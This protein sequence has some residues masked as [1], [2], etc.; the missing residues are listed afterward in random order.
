M[1][2]SDLFRV[3][4]RLMA[5]DRSRL[6]TRIIT[7]ILSA[8]S[9]MLFA[10]ASTAFFYS[11][12]DLYTRAFFYYTTEGYLQETYS[13]PSINH[14]PYTR[15]GV[16][17]EN[18]EEA[19]AVRQQVLEETGKNYIYMVSTSYRTEDFFGRT[20]E[21]WR[22]S[23]NERWESDRVRS[24]AGSEAALGELGFSLLAGNYPRERN[25]IA[26]RV[27]AYELFQKYGYRDVTEIYTQTPPADDG[28]SND[29]D[30]DWLDVWRVRSIYDL[31]EDSIYN[32]EFPYFYFQE[33]AA[34]DVPEE[35]ITDM[36][37]LIG[38]HLVGFRM[39]SDGQIVME[40]LE[41]VGIVDSTREKVGYWF[42]EASV[43]SE[44]WIADNPT[45]Y[46][47][48]ATPPAN[49]GEAKRAVSLAYDYHMAGLA[50]ETQT[51]LSLTNMDR[52]F[53]EEEQQFSDEWAIAIIGCVAGAFFGIFALLL[54]GHLTTRSIEAW[55]RQV[56]ILR[57]LGAGRGD[58]RLIFLVDILFTA[59]CVFLVALAGSLGL[60]YGLLYEWLLIPRFNVRLMQYT[61]WTVL[62][63]A[64]LCYAV[65]L[66]CAA[67]PVHKFF[68]KSIVDCIS[69]TAVPPKRRK[70]PHRAT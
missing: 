7:I 31:G 28:S 17:N 49:Y 42:E 36:Q 29:T 48:F 68:K 1:K 62:I 32:Y 47:M 57:S 34:L 8:F 67:L 33:R 46:I 55:Q 27:G 45:T 41:I 43:F 12:I 14:C 53:P 61:G 18:E 30:I 9:F 13:R 19:A 2:K 69:G 25:Q 5:R 66:L 24:V 3:G 20:D 56:G 63:L 23:Q 10:L 70:S 15:F 6:P 65:P 22:D 52:L 11:D 60:Y 50:G 58:I 40:P 26:L 59:T 39:L 64:A 16:Y 37:E 4:V 44:E 38:K 51:R 35:P 21:Y 54:N